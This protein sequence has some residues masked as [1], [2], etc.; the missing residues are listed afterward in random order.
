MAIGSILDVI[1]AKRVELLLDPTGTNDSFVTLQE[2]SMPLQRQETRE[3]VEGG[4]VYFYSQHDNAFDAVI[5]LTANDVGTYL[6]NNLLVNGALVV[7]TYDIRL[8]SKAGNIATIRVTAV[9]P[10]QNIEKLPD[11]GV[12]IYQTFRI[13]EDVNA[14]NL[15]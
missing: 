6:D 14:G 9:A 5:F 3:D 11:G 13:T 4:A 10:S 8:T 2:L 12:R 7:R 15:Q 1:N